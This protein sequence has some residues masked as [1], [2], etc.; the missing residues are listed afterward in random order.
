MLH[1][2]YIEYFLL[3][4]WNIFLKHAQ[5]LYWP[6]LNSMKYC[7]CNTLL[8]NINHLSKWN[9]SY[10]QL[11]LHGNSSLPLRRTSFLTAWIYPHYIGA[12]PP[13]QYLGDQMG[14]GGQCNV[15]RH[16]KVP[17]FHKDS[18]HY[19][20]LVSLFWGIQYYL[21]FLA[22]LLQYLKIHQTY[23]CKYSSLQGTKL[24]EYSMYA[25]KKNHI[26]MFHTE[27]SNTA[28]ASKKQATK[29]SAVLYCQLH[30]RC[31]CLQ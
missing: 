17:Q 8:I 7:T 27:I 13:L 15:A 18:M 19:L 21:N 31:L 6:W 1:K 11:F 25:V 28:S 24:T 20:G 9:N 29:Y 10:I 4:K 30:K 16:I 3:A 2:K 12:I 23:Y 22:I 26:K 5:S 14:S